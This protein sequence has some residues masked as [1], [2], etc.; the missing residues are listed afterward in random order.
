M[1]GETGL[2]I[3]RSF[4]SSQIPTGTGQPFKRLPIGGQ[5]VLRELH[6]C[7]PGAVKQSGPPSQ[8]GSTDLTSPDART[9][10]G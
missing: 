10:T 3:H 7:F 1:L 2:G 8:A 9:T 6:R 4:G 5:Q